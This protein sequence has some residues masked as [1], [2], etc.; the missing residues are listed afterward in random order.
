MSSVVVVGVAVVAGGRG[1]QAALGFRV[2]HAVR[3][4]SSFFD[5]CRYV[6]YGQRGEKE[7]QGGGTKTE[8]NRDH[9]IRWD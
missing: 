9:G 6:M 4:V 7:D 3:P 5:I 2:F 1:S 8:S